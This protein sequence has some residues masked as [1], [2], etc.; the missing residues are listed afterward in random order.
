MEC[1]RTTKTIIENEYCDFFPI[2]FLWKKIEVC[3]HN[4]VP[5]KVKNR[6]LKKIYRNCICKEKNGKDMIRMHYVGHFSL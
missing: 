1:S 4:L 3:K 5:F 2:K 6:K